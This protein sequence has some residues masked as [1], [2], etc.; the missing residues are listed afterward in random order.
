MGLRNRASN[1]KAFVRIERPE[2]WIKRSA[3]GLDGQTE[4]TNHLINLRGHADDV[5]KHLCKE[6]S[7]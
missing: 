4:D 7:S 5:F 1:Q 2:A 6:P 3:P